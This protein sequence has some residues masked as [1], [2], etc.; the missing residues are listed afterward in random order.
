MHL[1][2]QLDLE[3]VLSDTYVVNVVLT[4]LCVLL[5]L[6]SLVRNVHLCI[7]SLVYYFSGLG[8]GNLTTD[9]KTIFIFYFYIR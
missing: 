5:L 7:F 3:G 2:D 6:L 8:V 1:G 9:S 4:F